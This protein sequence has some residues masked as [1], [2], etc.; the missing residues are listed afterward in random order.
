EL[1]ADANYPYALV[2]EPIPAGCEVA[3]SDDISGRVS[4]PWNDGSYGTARQEVRDNKVL[5]YFN[6][7]RKGQT[8]LTYRLHA[9]TPG[10]YHILPT[11]GWLMYF[12]KVRGN[13]GLVKARIGESK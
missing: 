6:M 2:E 7:L 13:S 1:T 8:H 4:I 11:T 3:Q 12:P 10:L 5:F 9:E